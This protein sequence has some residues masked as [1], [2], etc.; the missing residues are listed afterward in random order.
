M[1]T[2]SCSKIC[3]TRVYPDDNSEKTIKIYICIDDRSNQS[4]A[5]TEFLDVK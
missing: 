3:L 4:L 1:S 5:R 2:R